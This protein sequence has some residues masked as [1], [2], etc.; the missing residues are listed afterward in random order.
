MDLVDVLAFGHAALQPG[1]VGLHDRLVERHR[2]QQGHVDAHALVDHLSD[3]RDALA[4]GGNLDQQVGPVDGVPQPPRLHD[5]L[6]GLERQIRADLDADPAV[7]AVGPVVDGPQDVAGHPDVVGGQLLE[8][9]RGRLAQGCERADVLVVVR[10]AADGLV[11][12]RRVGC[13][14]HDSVT[15]DQCAQPAGLDEAAADGVEPDALAVCWSSNSGFCAMTILVSNRY[16]VRRHPGRLSTIRGHSGRSPPV[17]PLRRDRAYA[18]FRSWSRPYGRPDRRPR[19]WQRGA[20]CLLMADDDDA[21]DVI[22]HEQLGTCAERGIQAHSDN[23]WVHEFTHA[24]LGPIGVREVGAEQIGAGDDAC[25]GA[26]RVGYNQ[27]ADIFIGHL[28]RRRQQRS[29]RRTGEDAEA[30]GMHARLSLA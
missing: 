30:F 3:R 8:D 26:I 4:R 29:V 25:E 2:E 24:I 18:S 27:R 10:T 5:R 14:T 15:V 28:A 9:L 7:N 12:D 6:L 20:A 17:S 22:V 19:R 16:L 13:D 1:Q 23:I 21:M 11:E